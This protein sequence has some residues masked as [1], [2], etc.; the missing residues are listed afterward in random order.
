MITG[1]ALR[2]AVST[3]ELRRD[4][5]DQEFT[6]SLLKFHDEDKPSPFDVMDRRMG[7]DM[8]IAKIQEVQA[9]YNLAIQV[10]VRG[11]PMSL[12]LAV[13]LL[14]GAGRTARLWKAAMESQASE[15][16]G[17]TGVRATDKIYAV[18]T[19]STDVAMAKIQSSAEYVGAL[20]AA[21]AEGNAVPMDLEIDASLLK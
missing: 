10:N 11:A 7:A 3:W 20:K 19:V 2:F 17:D 13:K 21:I 14:G 12:A 18:K 4:T 15:R 6:R 9:K 5:A 8:A 1:H 16:Y